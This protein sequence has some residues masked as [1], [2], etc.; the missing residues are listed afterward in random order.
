MKELKDLKVDDYVILRTNIDVSLRKI[1]AITPK[2]F[3]KV[4]GRL[5]NQSGIERT[6][7]IWNVSYISVPDENDIK[8]FINKQKILIL[9]TDI[10]QWVKDTDD[11]IK[12]QKIYEIIKG[13]I[14]G[15]KR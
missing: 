12:L 7:D 14:N 8:C 6:S 1:Q 13:E 15:R 3:I 4:S 10:Q 11:L 2:G 5:F 9:K